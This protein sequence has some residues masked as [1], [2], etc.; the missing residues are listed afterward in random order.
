MDGM[1]ASS[2]DPFT[3]SLSQAHSIKDGH[4]GGNFPLGG[5]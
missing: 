3:K 5:L 2:S 4:F 1:L